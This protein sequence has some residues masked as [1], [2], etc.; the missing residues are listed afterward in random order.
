M[1][2]LIYCIF[3]RQL[4]LS[5]VDFF[6]NSLSEERRHSLVTQYS[7][8]LLHVF[9]TMPV[10]CTKRPEESRKCLSSFRAKFWLKI[11][12]PLGAVHMPLGHVP[13]I[14]YATTLSHHQ[15]RCACDLKVISLGG[16][17][18]SLFLQLMYCSIG[19]KPQQFLEETI[20][21]TSKMF[22]V[23]RLVPHMIC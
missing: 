9:V 13:F 4:L 3:V 11:L 22:F 7:Y 5:T 21:L 20:F 1:L 2:F 17:L 16:C 23:S 14:D 18:V 8:G 19:R 10:D 15:G 6:Q 12:F